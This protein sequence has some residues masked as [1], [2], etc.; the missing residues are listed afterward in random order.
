MAQGVEYNSQ[1]NYGDDVISR[2]SYAGKPG[3]LDKLQQAIVTNLNQ[4]ITEMTQKAGVQETDIDQ[5]CVA[6]NTTMVQLLL[7][8][9]PEASAPGAIRTDGND[10]AHFSG[11]GFQTER[12]P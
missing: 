12:Q 6:A 10:S 11:R 3:G 5:I 4:L 2:I 1:R 7:G 9:D 8:L